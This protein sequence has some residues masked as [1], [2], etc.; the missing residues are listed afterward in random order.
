MFYL[1]MLKNVIKNVLRTAIQDLFLG[2][3]FSHEL[4]QMNF[5]YP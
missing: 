4:M 5:V 3:K 1:E 2:A